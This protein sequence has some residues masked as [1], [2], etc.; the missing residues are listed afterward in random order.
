MSHLH[1]LPHRHSPVSHLLWAS[2]QHG[3]HTAAGCSHG[4]TTHGCLAEPGRPWASRDSGHGRPHFSAHP[5]T[6]ADP[7]PPQGCAGACSLGRLFPLF[8]PSRKEELVN[9]GKIQALCCMGPAAGFLETRKWGTYSLSES[10]LQ[11]DLEDVNSPSWAS[12]PLS[13]CSSQPWGLLDAV[14]LK[15]MGERSW[16]STYN[17]W[18]PTSSHGPAATAVSVLGAGTKICFE[19]KRRIREIKEQRDDVSSN[20]WRHITS[21][22]AALQVLEEGAL[23][24]SGVQYG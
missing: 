18:T 21:L 16:G 15:Q 24:I 23:L 22:P 5:C 13:P 19:G 8:T 10:D 3:W 4:A 6:R 12:V 17:F 7:G 14:P 11:G 20:G 1:W 9:K 2:L